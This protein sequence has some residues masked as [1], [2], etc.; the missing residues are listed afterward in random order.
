MV[1]G[2][3]SPPF[4]FLGNSCCSGGGA[5]ETPGYRVVGR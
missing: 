4:T 5:R 2:G 3:M 1:E